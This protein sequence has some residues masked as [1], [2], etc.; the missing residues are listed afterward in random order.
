MYLY[1]LH[2]PAFAPLIKAKE[3]SISHSAP[4]D[5]TVVMIAHTSTEPTDSNT[6]VVPNNMS[7]TTPDK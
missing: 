1:R 2:T 5:G 6:T 3:T 4:P 7:T